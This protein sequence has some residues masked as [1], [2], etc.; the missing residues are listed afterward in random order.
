MGNPKTSENATI[1]LASNRRA[2]PPSN[3]RSAALTVATD[4]GRP[5][6]GCSARPKRA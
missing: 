2:R 5:K 1:S 3:D 6:C 4:H